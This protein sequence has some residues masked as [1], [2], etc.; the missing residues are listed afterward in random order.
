VISGQTRAASN[1]ATSHCPLA[2]TRCSGTLRPDRPKTAPTTPKCFDKNDFFRDA[3]PKMLASQ[4]VPTGRFA[5]RVS[6]R[7]VSRK[8]AKAP[9]SRRGSESHVRAFFGCGFAIPI[10]EIGAFSPGIVAQRQLHSP[11]SGGGAAPWVP[12]HGTRCE[13]I[14][15][16]RSGGIRIDRSLS[17]SV[18]EHA[19][20]R[21]TA[22]TKL[23][24]RR[25]GLQSTVRP[26][27]RPRK[28]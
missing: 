22:W 6:W 12:T 20:S 7:I 15:K 2:T 11:R 16:P 3:K 13:S 28:K 24:A 4:I 10:E 26:R 8:G 19:Q 5:S 23:A 25:L 18:G 21:D 17:T 1:L 14:F 27:G 9:R